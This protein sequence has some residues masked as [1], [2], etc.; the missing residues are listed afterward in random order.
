MAATGQNPQAHASFR[1]AVKI[2]D[3]EQATFNECILPSLQVDIEERREGGYN[4]GVHLLPGRVKSGR[5]TLKS[6]TTQSREMLAWYREVANGRLKERQLSIVMYDAASQPI[7]RLNFERVY[8]TK[9]TGP[10]FKAS[11][12]TIA[13]E[14]L[15][16]AYSEVTFE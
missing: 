12:S 4:S 15:E 5:L 13:I 11:E 6:G 3:Q 2:D 9:W 8:P 10:T 7:M 16:L 14:S 1:F